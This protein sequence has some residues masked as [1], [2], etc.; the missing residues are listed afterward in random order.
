MKYNC[1]N[2]EVEKLLIRLENITRSHGACFH[3]DLTVNLKNG[4]LHISCKT[5]LMPGEKLIEMPEACL[6]S[7][8]KFQMRVQ[9]RAI[10]IESIEADVPDYQVACFEVMTEIFNL[11]NK[12]DTYSQTNV[13]LAL[14]DET[15]FLDQLV[16]GRNKAPKVNKYHGLWQEG[17]LDRLLLESFFGSRWFS[18]KSKINSQQQVLMPFI[19]YL[20]HHQQA[21]GYRFNDSLLSVSLATPLAGSDEC[22][23]CYNML[24]A[25]DALLV[26]GFVDKSS[27]FVRSVPLDIQFSD[28]HS[29][30]NTKLLIGS[31]VMG[32]VAKKNLPPRVQDLQLFMPQVLGRN[33]ESL[34]IS[35]ILIPGEKAPRALRRILG[36]FIQ[37]L[38]PGKGK[39]YLMDQ[40]LRAEHAVIARNE[41]YF[42]ELARACQSLQ[43][44]HPGKE[45][46]RQISH[47]CDIQSAR[48]NAYRLRVG[49]SA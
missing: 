11:C 3:P 25:L 16:G 43:Q 15:E 32:K 14:N 13:W 37:R 27:P 8:E 17:Q 44:K 7:K 47:L 42:A 36:F 21:S 10:V 24:D 30:R 48:L 38:F 5:K 26:Y 4:D 22:F 9:G 31:Q 46:L 29:D 6:P 2:P 45:I 40:V 49:M 33:N 18:L 41:T 35:H 34:Q 20:N 28:L 1:D 23:V 12:I 19:D 39:S